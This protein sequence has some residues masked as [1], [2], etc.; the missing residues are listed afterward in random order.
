M[1]LVDHRAN[2][3]LAD[4]V[5]LAPERLPISIT[6]HIVHANALAVEWCEILPRPPVLRPASW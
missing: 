4:R 5:G 3:E 6:A 1:F 2:R